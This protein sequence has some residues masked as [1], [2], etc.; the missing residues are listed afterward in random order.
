MKRRSGRYSS[1]PAKSRHV[2]TELDRLP[3]FRLPATNIVRNLLLR[4]FRHQTLYWIRGDLHS[5]RERVRTALKRTD[6]DAVKPRAR[7]LNVGCG[8]ECVPGEG[9]LNLDAF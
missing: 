7:F 3:I 4:L 6:P 5:L 1:A 9:W 2:K 8:D